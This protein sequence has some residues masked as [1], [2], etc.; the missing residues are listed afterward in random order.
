MKKIIRYTILFP[1]IIY[2]GLIL[3]LFF[4]Q[5]SLVYYPDNTAFNDCSTFEQNE[6]KEYN[7]THFYEHKGENN[8]L[9]VFFHGNAGRA[10]DRSYMKQILEKTHSSII[11]VEYFGYSDNDNSPNIESILQDVKN[12]GNYVQKSDYENIFLFG[13]SI[14]SGPASYYAQNF[15]VDKLLLISPFSNLYEPGKN[16]YP[17]LP[18]KYIFTENFSPKEYL[19]NYKNDLLIIH[20]DSDKT[21]PTK[22]GINLYEGLK[23]ENKNL[24]LVKGGDHNN[25]FPDDNIEEKIINFFN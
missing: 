14:G 8:N 7:G 9:I 5:K 17:Y 24:V 11:F 22:Y 20:G 13:R 12:I 6:Q 10:C 25:L 4:V 16:I 3:F 2:I 21:V 18:I 1:A 15:L 23:N 19:E